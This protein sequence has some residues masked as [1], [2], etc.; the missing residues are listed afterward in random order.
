MYQ[1]YVVIKGKVQGVY[2]RKYT[3]EK[4]LALNIT[5]W[6]QNA[7]D[8]SVEAVF[9]TKDLKDLETMLA[10]CYEGSPLSQVT[11]VAVTTPEI[12]T[13]YTTFSINY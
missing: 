2:F 10:W 11:E 6:V 1:S 5:G 9:Q 7:P 4:A 3:M 12:Q 13:V 8:N